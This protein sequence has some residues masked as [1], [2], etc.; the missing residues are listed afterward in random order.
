M[1]RLRRL[2]TVPMKIQIQRVIS[3]FRSMATDRLQRSMMDTLRMWVLPVLMAAFVVGDDGRAQTLDLDNFE[4]VIVEEEEPARGAQAHF[5]IAPRQFDQWMF[6]GGQSAGQSRRRLES[7]LTLHVESIDRVCRL[8]DPQ[9]EK[10]ELAG[11]GDIKRFFEEVEEVRRQ[12]MEVRRD[13]QRFNKIWQKISPLRTK[14]NVGIFNRDS[15]IYKVLTKTLHA[16]QLASYQDH[17]LQRRQFH[18]RAKV[19]MVV[20]MLEKGIPLRDEQRQTFIKLIVDETD[21]PRAFGQHDF[22]VVL[23]QISKLPE[24]KVKPIFDEGQWLA[25]QASFRRAKAMERMLRKENLIP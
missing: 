25:L 2:K 8:S 17:S 4:D 14:L 20:A 6:G 19:A 15:L 11:H 22:Y 5:E 10:L 12:F 3:D 1:N 21:P 9:R 18:Y 7:Q 13:R 16:D 24:D 23:Y